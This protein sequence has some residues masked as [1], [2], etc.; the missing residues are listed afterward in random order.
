MS[1]SPFA[2]QFLINEAFSLKSRLKSV[3]PFALTSPMVAAACISDPALKG[4]TD[5]IIQNTKELNGR[6]DSFIN[7]I[8][9]PE[10]KSIN[11]EEA[12]AKF[13]MLKLRFNAVL[14]QLD[15]FSNVVTQRSEHETGIWVAGLDVLATDALELNPK[16]Y[17]A[18]ELVCF[19]TRGHGAAIRRARTRLPGGDENP[20]GVIQVPRERMIG[21][22]IASSLVHE[23]G[24][25][26]AA[27]LDL[28]R[29]L[30]EDIR[31]KQAKSSN[32]TG[33]DLYHR[34]IS[35]IVADFWAMSH[36]GIGATVGLISVVSLPR[37]FMFRIRG[38]DPHPFPWIRVKLSFSFG[39]ALYPDAQ[40]GK[41]ERLWDRMY[42]LNKVDAKSRQII[43]SLDAAMPAF[44]QLL[45]NHRSKELKGKKLS[46]IFP[47]KTRTPAQLRALLTT[48]KTTPAK[49]NTAPPT[50]VFAVIGQ[51]HAD[52]KISATVESRVLSKWLTQWAFLRSESRTTNE[53]KNVLNQIK[54]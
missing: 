22:G 34:W 19:I 25:Q 45:I 31:S 37:Y 18:P 9:S 53:S 51:A 38:N 33:W 32:K 46:E 43:K 7:E 13:S 16:M 28:V 8:S 40:W 24:H 44:T 2:T 12:Q 39:K 50:L 10:G 4:I 17:D 36:L 35:E 11:T 20:V 49:M 5:L 52:G 15:I 26:G 54:F 14:D 23:V 3:R 48:W 29:T 6:I 21:S 1:R 30:R 41:F 47:Y 42:P 27:L